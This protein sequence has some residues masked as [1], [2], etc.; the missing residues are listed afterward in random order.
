MRVDRTVLWDGSWPQY[1]AVGKLQ[2]V[3]LVK[4][5]WKDRPEW[6]IAP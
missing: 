1:R 2:S 5:F 4:L 3:F 6:V